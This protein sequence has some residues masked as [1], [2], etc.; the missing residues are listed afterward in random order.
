[1]G[2]D[3]REFWKKTILRTVGRVA[4]SIDIYSG[5]KKW[6]KFAEAITYVTDQSI[7]RVFKC[8]K[9]APQRHAK[10]KKA[11][12]HVYEVVLEL[13]EDRRERLRQHP[14]DEESYD[15]LD[16]MLMATIDEKD[17]KKIYMTNELI[18]ANL[19]TILSAGHSTTTAM[20][21]WTLNYL[22]DRSLGNHDYLYKLIQEVDSVSEGNRR[23]EPTVDDVF[24]RMD[25]LTKVLYETLRVMPPI[26]T[27]VRHCIKTSN[28]G[29]YLIQR[30]TKIMISAL[31]TH[32]HP[33]SW[34]DAWT[35]NPERW[36]EQ[37]KKACAFIPWAS[38]ARQCIGREF[39]MFTGRIA[40][41]SMINQFALEMSPKSKVE[42]CEHLFVFPKGLIMKARPR[43]NLKPSQLRKK[44]DDK[45][46]KEK[47]ENN[48]E[49]E[50]G[51]DGSPASDGKRNWAGLM[52]LI[53]EEGYK[54]MVIEGTNTDSGNVQTVAQWLVDKAIKFSFKTKD[55]PV[56]PDEL[57]S[58]IKDSKPE[59]FQVW[60]FVTATYNGKP[61]NNAKK[62]HKWVKEKVK[63]GDENYLE[64]VRYFVF[65][66]GNTN[67]STTYQKMPEFFD[68]N[69]E[70][71]GAKRISEIVHYDSSQD[72]LEEVFRDYY[73]TMAPALMHSLPEIGDKKLRDV[74]EEYGGSNAD[75]RDGEEDEDF[76]SESKFEAQPSSSGLEMEVVGSADDENFKEDYIPSA[77]VS[78]DK[79]YRCKVK[80]AKNL[81]PESGRSTIHLALEIPEE[82]EYRAGDHLVVIPKISKKTAE[83]LL[84]HF[85]DFDFE[86]VIKFNC[87]AKKA[88][89][90]FKL[91]VDTCYTVENILRSFVDLNG[92]PS[93]QFMINYSTIVKSDEHAETLE[94]IANDKSSYTEWLKE[95]EP[96]SV[97]DIID[98]YPPKEDEF[99]RLLEILPV[100]STRTY[101]ITSSPNVHKNEVHI[102]AGVI[103]NG[104]F[105]GVCS[106]YFEG[107]IDQEDESIYCYVDKADD[108]FHIPDDPE[109]TMILISAG[110]GFAPMRSFLHERHAQEAKGSNT[111]FFGCRTEDKDVLYKEELDGWKDDKFIDIHYAYSRS[112]KYEKKYVQDV[113][114]E[115]K[116]IVWKAINEHD[117]IIYV[118]GC[119]SGMGAGVRDALLEI[120]KEHSDKSDDEDK[121]EW[122][123]EYMEKLEENDRYL[124]DVWG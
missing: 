78:K 56:S 10:F 124:L 81:T 37:P 86:T 26:P 27:L 109:K 13:V 97:I 30:G 114:K 19:T 36:E 53:Q 76:S 39:A 17:G 49:N 40:L 99:D 44:N 74:N 71:L 47:K 32:L 24:K 107:M 60:G 62:F 117:A 94:T 73:K 82:M 88:K 102:C 9:M 108:A 59:E 3:A 118:C 80:E 46:K 28:V 43:A 93:K 113:I 123:N 18:R 84:E 70:K 96:L 69:L 48:E 54:S 16:K 38:G 25:F 65:G 20:L 77:V 22:Y 116:D 29:G 57:L 23:Y 104:S 55:S 111:V 101:S 2:F 105:K 67:W 98:K 106:A 89:K 87:S 51:D 90:R 79:A 14:K 92:K 83:R 91:P 63:D 6:E 121:E 103:E 4:M 1:M 31:G 75:A 33:K 7:N 35:Y 42:P 15:L 120:F 100:L 66:C 64:N 5:A 112:E 122:A 110:T 41:F 115:K 21:S 50:G 119:G 58:E 72:D 45:E 34:D 12:K 95:N 85:V 61:P 8:A 52:N 68:E 11:A